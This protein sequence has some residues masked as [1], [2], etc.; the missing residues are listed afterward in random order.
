MSTT[1]T[2]KILL[3]LRDCDASM[4]KYQDVELGDMINILAALI[5]TSTLDLLQRDFIPAFVRAMLNTG[6]QLNLSYEV[7]ECLARLVGMGPAMSDDPDEWQDPSTVQDVQEAAFGL[8]FHIDGVIHD[9]GETFFERMPEVMRIAYSG[10]WIRSMLR[11]IAAGA[12]DGFGLAALRSLMGVSTL[13]R[14]MYRKIQIEME[15]LDIDLDLD[16]GYRPDDEV[17]H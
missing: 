17:V 9:K 13:K 4:E 14:E 12:E 15:R 8:L 6:R 16:L 5:M 3:S 1:V 7:F 11:S 2:E 10:I